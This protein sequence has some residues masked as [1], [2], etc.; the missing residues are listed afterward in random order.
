MSSQ[1]SSK[2]LEEEGLEEEE[3]RS[4]FK[5]AKHHPA[6]YVYQRKRKRSH[7]ILTI[8]III[9]CCYVIWQ[10]TFHPSTIHRAVDHIHNLSQ[11][12]YRRISFI[13]SSSSDVSSS[14][15][16][17]NPGIE[18]EDDA[19]TDAGLVPPEARKGLPSPANG[20]LSTPTTKKHHHHPAP[21]SFESSKREIDYLLRQRKSSHDTSWMKRFSSFL[22]FS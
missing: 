21:Q 4:S 22:R 8:L 6:T 2:S 16:S 15:Y 14:S 5:Q 1:K 18:S 17:E 13:P 3:R 7:V 9:G 11:S 12:A 10:I 20:T 19:A